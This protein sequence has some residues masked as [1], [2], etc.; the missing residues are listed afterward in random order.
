M[1]WKW[2]LVFLAKNGETPVEHPVDMPCFFGY[3]FRLDS[4]MS[5]VEGTMPNIQSAKK[6]MELSRAANSRNRVT[7]SQIKTA[8]RRV[9]EAE[10]AETAQLH[11]KEAVALLDRAA[12]KNLIHANRVGRLKSQL[13]RRVND[14]SA[15]S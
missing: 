1:F 12:T 7:R 5:F 6:R 4:P 8:I 10:N 14:L 13:A 15:A 11:M 2:G 9:A 3:Y